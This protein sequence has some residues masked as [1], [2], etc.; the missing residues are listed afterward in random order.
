MKIY[1]RAWGAVN[2]GIDCVDYGDTTP[3]PELP[4]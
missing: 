1:V 3:S 4:V 2:T